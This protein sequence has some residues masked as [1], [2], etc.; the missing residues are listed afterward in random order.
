MDLLVR[1]SLCDGR[2]LATNLEALL[3]VLL[4]QSRTQEVAHHV[5][6]LSQVLLLL[7]HFT[8]SAATRCRQHLQLFALSLNVLEQ[9][10]RAA[11]Q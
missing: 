1:V 10:V 5:V 4:E 6:L 9:P 11:S 3:I 7:C 2:Q 8:V